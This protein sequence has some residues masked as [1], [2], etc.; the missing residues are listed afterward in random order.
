MFDDVI[1]LIV[2][3]SFVGMDQKLIF[4]VF[5]WVGVLLHT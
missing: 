2:E 1:L 5:C 4:S 3:K